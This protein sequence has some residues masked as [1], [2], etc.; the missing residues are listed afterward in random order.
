MRGAHR[1][2]QNL[3]NLH[4]MKLILVEFFIWGVHKGDT[5][6]IWGYAEGYNF[7]LGV[8]KYQKIENP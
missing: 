4:Q 7:Y 3:K 2:M 8:G 5:V 6:L 1:G